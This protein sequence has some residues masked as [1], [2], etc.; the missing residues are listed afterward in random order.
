MITVVGSLKGGTGKT[1]LASNLC[2]MRSAIGKKVLLVDADEQLSTTIWVNRRESLGFETKWTTIQLGGT[3]LRKQ[4]ERMMPDYDDII[5]D[6][7][8]RHTPALKSSISACDI[9]LIPFKPRPFDIW[10]LSDMKSLV[11]E[12]IPANPKMKAY[13]V[14]NQADSTGSDNDAS[15]TALNESEEIRCL[16]FTIGSRKAF[17]NAAVDGLGVIELKNGDKKAIQEIQELYKFIYE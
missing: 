12:M 1:T 3:L 4:V 8:G 16:D 15:I 6:V 7:G 10:T 17:S 9:L 2:V 11:S 13:A 5:I 14:I